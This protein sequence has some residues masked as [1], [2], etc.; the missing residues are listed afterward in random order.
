MTTMNFEAMT[1]A[2]VSAALAA[3]RT[4]KKNNTEVKKNRWSELGRELVETVVTESGTTASEYSERV[5]VSTPTLMV[6]I[7]GREY[8][9]YVSIKDVKASEDRADAIERG[10][11][12][13][14]KKKSK[15]STDKAEDDADDATGDE[16][17][18][19]E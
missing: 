7:E 3:L 8:T 2:E 13:L 6:E 12:T 18:A 14:K 19:D 17:P 4:I 5:G 10:E 15:K 11:V 1:D 9:Y 16:G